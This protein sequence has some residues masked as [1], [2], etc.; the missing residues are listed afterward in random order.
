MTKEMAQTL[1]IMK[2]SCF[3]SLSS[4][5]LSLF[6]T[7]S[8]S[9]SF[10]V[11]FKKST[12]H[13]CLFFNTTLPLTSSRSPPPPHTGAKFSNRHLFVW[14]TVD[15][16]WCRRLLFMDR[17]FQFVCTRTNCSQIN[18]KKAIVFWFLIWD[19]MPYNVIY[20]VYTSINTAYLRPISLTFFSVSLFGLCHP[21]HAIHLL[22]PFQCQ[23]PFPYCVYQIFHKIHIHCWIND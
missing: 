20:I 23:T 16:I 5:S 22:I 18:R 13:L 21:R 12:I 6:L 1:S 4:C 7:F 19:S 3:F 11:C 2:F 9:Q 17:G 10:Q 14:V 8:L 15:C